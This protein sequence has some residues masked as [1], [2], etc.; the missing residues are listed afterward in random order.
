M[1]VTITIPIITLWSAI[2]LLLQMFIVTGLLGLLVIAIPAYLVG[3]P[4]PLIPFGIFLIT[5]SI[6]CLLS[7][8]VTDI[9][10]NMPFINWVNLTRIE[11]P[12]KFEVI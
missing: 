1:T 3:W 6:F 8:V 10:S 11:L 4:H 12:V 2:P 9:S 7:F 5:I